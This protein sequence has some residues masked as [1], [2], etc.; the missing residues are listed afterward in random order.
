[1]RQ[2]T[3]GTILTSL[4]AHSSHRRVRVEQQETGD[5]NVPGWETTLPDLQVHVHELSAK[6]RVARGDAYTPR[7]THSGYCEYH[8]ALTPGARLVEA[9]RRQENGS[10]EPV[11]GAE[12]QK[13]Q[14]L[15][16]NYLAGFPAPDT[17]VALDLH[18]MEP[19]R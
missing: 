10:W 7:Q 6:E 17:Q 15:G 9:H 16:V 8:A 1:M 2:H 13:W 11:A 18:R 3:T 4:M 19:T 14:I 12:A 5:L